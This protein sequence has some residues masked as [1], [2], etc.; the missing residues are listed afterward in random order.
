MDARLW[1]DCFYNDTGT[2]SCWR[3]TVLN[4]ACSAIFCRPAWA[5]SVLMGAGSSVRSTAMMG[6]TTTNSG[7]QQEFEASAK[8]LA[9]KYHDLRLRNSSG[10]GGG[11]SSEEHAA[12][13][14][15][16]E[17]NASSTSVPPQAQSSMSPLPRAERKRLSRQLWQHST[18][19]EEN[20]NGAGSKVAT[21]NP[22]S[23][24]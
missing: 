12:V 10:G 11:V 1:M 23:E 14:S 22:G 18:A 2:G 20:I 17:L 19:V 9:S 5:T 6:P 3:N 16:L 4:Q 8:L 24:R 15:A 13:P 7:H 21:A